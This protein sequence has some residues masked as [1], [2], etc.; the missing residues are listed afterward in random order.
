MVN[1]R[2]DSALLRL[3]KIAVSFGPCEILSGLD[4]DIYPKDFISILGPSGV[5]KTTLLRV[6]AGL[7]SVSSGYIY[8]KSVNSGDAS[9]RIALVPQNPTLLP[10]RNVISNAMMGIKSTIVESKQQKDFVMEKLEL[11]GLV[12]S[13]KKFPKELSG[14]MQQRV[15]IA[16]ALASAPDLVLM[17]EPFS[18]LDEQLRNYLSEMVLMISIKEELTVIFNTHSVDEATLMSTRICVLSKTVRGSCIE[19]F[20]TPWKV[21]SPFINFYMRKSSQK[22]LD[23]KQSVSESMAMASNILT[24]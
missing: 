21:E 23:L 13:S 6:L 4:F 7:Q 18:A 1:Q 5:G 14:G 24:A 20:A 19:E 17:D 15:A 11:V 2:E 16:R 8:K 3:D 9:L 10:W 22:R 12:D